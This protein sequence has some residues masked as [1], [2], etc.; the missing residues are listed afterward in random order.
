MT[1]RCTFTVTCSK[2]NNAKA[3]AWL[4]WRGLRVYM[5]HTDYSWFPRQKRVTFAIISREG[6]LRYKVP[7]HIV[8]QLWTSD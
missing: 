3:A 6:E 2:Q 5:E 8:P 4:I 1:L 7:L